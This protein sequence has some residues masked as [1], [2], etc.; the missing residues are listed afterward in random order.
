MSYT[1]QGTFK[2]SGLSKKSQS[3]HTNNP[4]TIYSACVSDIQR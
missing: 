2:L 3:L 4:E 1:T